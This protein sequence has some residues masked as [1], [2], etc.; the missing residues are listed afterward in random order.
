MKHTI[1]CIDDELD[2]VDALERIFRRKYRVLKAVSGDEGLE[3]LKKESSVS[4]IISDQRMPRMT[5]VEFF[6]KSLK[7]HP[8]TMRILLT[9]Y[10][11]IASVVEAINSGEVYRYV[12]KPWD[13]VDLA[14]TVDKAI[15]KFELRQELLLKNHELEKALTELKSLD[16]AKT[17]FMFLINHEL[18]T[19]LTVLMSYLDLLKESQLTEEQNSYWLRLQK[20]TQ[21]LAAIINEV[22]ELVAAETGQLKI[23]NNKMDLASLLNEIQKLWQERCQDRQLSWSLHI[24]N[25]K[26]RGDRIIIENILKRLTD[27]ATK[28]AQPKSTIDVF[29]HRDHLN[30]EFVRLRICN[31]GKTLSE[32]VINKILKPFTLDEEMLHHSKGLGMGLS[33]CQALLKTHQS[34]LEIQSSKGKI[35]V[36]FRL[37]SA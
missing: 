10:T 7:T 32:Q 9:G 14:N 18:K 6:K 34:G 27:N 17:Q 22:L 12:T 1:L 16:E 21:Q 8:E 37:P 26:V 29:I 36:S 20:S 28:F 25:H 2:N 31:M 19:P 13:P 24:E 35:E 33:I 23:H 11:D 5:G 30:E 3:H 15:E 4:L